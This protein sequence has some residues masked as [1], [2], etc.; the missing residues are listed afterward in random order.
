MAALLNDFDRGAAVYSGSRRIGYDFKGSKS[1]IHPHKTSLISLLNERPPF[2]FLNRI[3]NTKSQTN[4]K[5]EILMCNHMPET[6][7]M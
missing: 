3:L 5:L 7:F 2:I 1:S 4:S 6:T